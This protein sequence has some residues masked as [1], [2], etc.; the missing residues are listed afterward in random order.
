MGN[1]DRVEQEMKKMSE[2]AQR[3][4]GSESIKKIS[5]VVI[6][7]KE[8]QL[9]QQGDGRMYTTTNRGEY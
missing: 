6:N 4:Y 8:V 2:Q 3:I 1:Y 7:G 5:T 9:V